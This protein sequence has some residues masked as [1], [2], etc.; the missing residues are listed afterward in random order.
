MRLNSRFLTAAA[1]VLAFAVLLC[2]AEKRILILNGIEVP[3]SI[4]EV[5][6]RTYVE[7]EALARAANGSI[8]YQSNHILLDLPAEATPR[9]TGI[10]KDFARSGVAALA[11]MREWKG[12]VEASLDSGLV[13]Q[14][15]WIEPHRVEAQHALAQASLATKTQADRDA[16][17]LIQNEFSQLQLWAQNAVAERKALNATHTMSERGRQDDEALSKIAQCGRFLTFF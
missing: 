2:S 13:V 10:S 8:H 3:G 4:T 5:N 1:L 16:A 17:T 14:E 9:Q 12:V 11:Q 6:G 7:L 15:S